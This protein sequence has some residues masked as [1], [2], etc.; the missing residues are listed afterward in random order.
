MN[1]K[2]EIYAVFNSKTIRI[3]QAY[4]EKIA[5]EAVMLNTFG[6]SFN[7]NRM[8]WIK[9]SFLWMMYR[10]NWGLKKDQD[11]IL[12]VD[13]LRQ[14]FDE[15]LSHAILT[16]DE[17]K[18]FSSHYE[19]NQAFVNSEVYCQWDPDRDI[20]GKAIGRTAIQIGIRGQ[21]VKDYLNK[22]INKVSDIT[23]D[24][25][26]LRAQVINGCLKKELL[27]KEKVYPVSNIIRKK[28]N[29]D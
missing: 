9:P 15:Y 6:E 19:W 5:K 12:A 14:G 2:K 23:S 25:I 11:H 3:Y 16:T 20:W 21:A 7:L 28:L 17:S 18:I 10:S 22:W 24:I 1:T 27:P 4:N 13:I 29:M 8:T 26:K